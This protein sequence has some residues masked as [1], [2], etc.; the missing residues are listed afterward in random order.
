MEI[1]LAERGRESVGIFDHLM[2]VADGKAKPIRKGF[3]LFDARRKQ[4][5]F[6]DTHKACK[7][8]IRPAIKKLDRAR[9]RLKRPDD[10]SA[11]VAVNAQEGERIAMCSFG[12]LFRRACIRHSAAIVRKE[13]IT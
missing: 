11:A 1:E 7:R 8:P 9:L 6:M 3:R 4:A 10:E 5:G 2:P 13:P 12:D